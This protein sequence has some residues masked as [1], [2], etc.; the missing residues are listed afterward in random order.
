MAA[1]WALEWLCKQAPRTQAEQRGDKGLRTG[2]QA[3]P[4]EIATIQLR[5]IG[6]LTA[7]Y[8]R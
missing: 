4:E 6:S 1:A 7:E 2:E 8:R 3:S 5:Y